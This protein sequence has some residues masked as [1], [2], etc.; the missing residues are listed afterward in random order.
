MIPVT[1]VDEAISSPTPL[2]LWLLQLGF[3]TLTT[4]TFGGRVILSW[5]VVVM[6]SPALLDV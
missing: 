1:K 3:S 2:F 5:G 6:P 4:L